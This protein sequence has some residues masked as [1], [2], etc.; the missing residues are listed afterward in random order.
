MTTYE[1][2]RH[3][4]KLD[5]KGDMEVMLSVRYGKTGEDGNKTTDDA[6]GFAETFSVEQAEDG[7]YFLVV[8]AVDM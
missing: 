4:V 7:P 6:C 8:E 5:P 2:I 1:L 3:L